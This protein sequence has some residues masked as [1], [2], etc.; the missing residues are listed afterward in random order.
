MKGLL[1]ITLLFMIMT[2]FS[3][4]SNAKKKSYQVTIQAGDWNRIDTVVTFQLPEESTGH[5]YQLRGPNGERIPVQI[6]A[7]N[8]ANFILPNLK[9]GTS[10][11][12]QL[13]EMK[14]SKD[15]NSY[16]KAEHV[17][18][19]I[20]I[21]L[22]GSPVISYQGGKGELPRQDIKPIFRRG[23]YIQSV[24]T[25]GGKIVTD[26]YPPNHLHH[27]G[28]WFA[29]TETKFEDR[30]PDFWNM[31]EGT[32]TV[33][34]ESFGDVWSGPVMA[35][36]KSHHR[37][38]DLSALQPKGV[39]GEEWEVKV[40][41]VG[42]GKKPYR[43]FDLTSMQKALTSSP[44]ILPKYLYGG[45]GFRG[46]WQWNGKQNTIFLTSEGK[47]RET[48]HGT[49]ARWCHIGGLIDGKLAGLAILGHPGNFRAPQPMRIHP[50]EPFF[51]YAPPQ[52]G[53]MQVASE[54]YVSRYR[55]IVYDGAPDKEE[56][57]RLWNDYANPPRIT[58]SS[59]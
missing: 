59:K 48:G 57:D 35:G 4:N 30:R 7:R 56:L 46:N 8:Q 34:F 21:S 31:G 12:Y 20:N 44:L 38:V 40:Y 51:C 18:D 24:H 19:N 23:G 10:R 11:Q 22:N 41:R 42:D 49:Q 25:P 32:G 50:D 52:A 53:E 9:A 15:S 36:F 28:I 43:M 47:D 17:K 58:I 27:H 39:L 13:E 2:V 54:E 3:S 26:D 1:C 29:W 16:M 14:L 55:F 33:E 37:F 6:T 5:L 45:L